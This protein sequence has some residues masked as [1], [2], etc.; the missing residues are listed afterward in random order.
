MDGFDFTSFMQIWRNSDA[1]TLWLASATPLLLLMG[2]ALDWLI[3]DPLWLPHPVVVMGWWIQTLRERLEPWA[4]DR[5]PQLR[6]AGVL[7]TLLLISGTTMIGWWV[8][9]LPQRLPYLGWP[10]LVIALAS[11]LAGRSLRQS[12]MAVLEVLPSRGATGLESA[13]ER[14]GRIVGR[15]PARQSCAKDRQYAEGRKLHRWGL[16]N[17][18]GG[19]GG[20]NRLHSKI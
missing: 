6:L 15:C 3:G 7:I 20:Q 5:A 18:C 4:G 16:R 11:A 17:C 2:L 1:Q 19:N 8:E 13:R 12:V 10:L 14:L 9:R